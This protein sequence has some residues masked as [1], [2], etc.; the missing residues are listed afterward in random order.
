SETVTH[1]EVAGG[2]EL[3]FESAQLV[4]RERG[5]RPARLLRLARIPSR[6]HRGVAHERRTRVNFAQNV[7]HHES[8][9]AQRHT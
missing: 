3:G 4:K 9:R 6:F 7:G 8:A 5:S 2:L 1:R